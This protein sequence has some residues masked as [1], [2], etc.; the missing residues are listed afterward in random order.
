MKICCKFFPIISLFLL[1]S[2]SCKP[3]DRLGT[4]KHITIAIV[5]PSIESLE[6][7]LIMLLSDFAWE[8]KP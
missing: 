8:C 3:E 5:N 6:R 4:E 2:F 7:I 1:V